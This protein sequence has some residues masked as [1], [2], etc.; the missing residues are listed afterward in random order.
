M[1]SGR[2]VGEPLSNNKPTLKFNVPKN[3][4]SMTDPEREHKQELAGLK[5]K[6]H[7][8]L[9]YCFVHVGVLFSLS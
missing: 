6:S 4:N 9:T 5:L 7:T 2:F 8:L 3:I 1:V